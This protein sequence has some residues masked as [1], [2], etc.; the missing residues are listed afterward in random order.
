MG[1]SAQAFA[2]R[3]TGTALLALLCVLLAVLAGV[4]QVAHVHADGN[5]EHANCS[6]CV[7]AHV[8]VQA[9]A[10]PAPVQP[11]VVTARVEPRAERH[12]AYRLGAFALFIRPPPAA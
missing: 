12:P 3:R 4:A 8:G 5:A 6:L 1:I 9:A 10:S 2:R 7:V 11:L